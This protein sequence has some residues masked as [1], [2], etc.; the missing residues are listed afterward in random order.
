MKINR[1]NRV[2]AY[3]ALAP[4]LVLGLGLAATATL[5]SHL[6]ARELALATLR[7]EQAALAR[8]HAIERSLLDVAYALRLFNGFLQGISLE[9]QKG[10]LPLAQPLLE[11]FPF[12]EGLAFE[13]GAIGNWNSA[14]Q[15]ISQASAQYAM[16]QKDESL[17]Q[18]VMISRQ[19]NRF[20]MAMPIYGSEQMTRSL[21]GYSVA[22]FDAGK[23][24][25]YALRRARLED[26]PNFEVSLYAGRAPDKRDLVFRAG[27]IGRKVSSR[28]TSGF[29]WPSHESASLSR[30]FDA[31]GAPWHVRVQSSAEPLDLAS[32]TSLLTLVAGILFS[33][34][35]AAF[36]QVLAQ[37]SRRILR[38]NDQRRLEL[39]AANSRL[40]RDV[41]AREQVEQ[42]L[43]HTER[44]L[45][46]AQKVAHLGSWELD[47]TTGELQC[48]D[49]LFR[50]FGLA[51]QSIRPTLDI[52]RAMVHPDDL[53]AVDAAIL[54]ARN[55]GKLFRNEQRIVRPDGSV[56]HVVMVGVVTRDDGGNVAK[57]TGS[58]S[59]VTEQK[60]TELALRQSEAELRQLAAHQERL[61]EE[62][63]KRIAREVHDEL[64]SMLTGIKAYLSVSMERA[65]RAGTP[66]DQLLA[67]ASDLADQASDTMRKVIADLR[68][69]VLDQL[70]VWAALQWYAEQTAKRT[71]LACECTI[72]ERAASTL[73]DPDRG[74][75][76]FRIVQEALTNVVRHARASRVNIRIMRLADSIMVEV[77]DDG[78]GFDLKAT[79]QRTS[80]GIVGMQERA[81]Y[82][83]G[84]FDIA[85]TPGKGTIARLWLPIDNSI[86]GKND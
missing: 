69:S 86:P 25:A 28:A 6:Q 83:G 57:V 71:G 56:R 36:M 63:R 73:I 61:L 50:I 32:S 51:P 76:L 2:Q 3:L 17:P 49:E 85:A 29:G 12:I 60:Q 15:D 67:D 35:V 41:A 72:S 24:A 65:R 22:M 45:T 64:G 20:V 13:R 33:F 18:Q 23:L 53:E 5:Y 77:E 79:Q 68:P 10:T 19:K 74:I 27:K 78:A 80:W 66:M 58:V 43:R 54:E 8:A 9:R 75:V 34:L 46:V 82:F 7:F 1:L 52:I 38:M 30:T 84:N 55:R 4:S 81:R 31:S 42:A 40:Q 62:E 11:R 37:R 26:A 16:K 14:R 48:S 47:N 39:S 70:G 59:D 21:A 44:V